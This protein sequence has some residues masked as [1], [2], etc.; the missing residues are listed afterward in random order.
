MDEAPEEVSICGENKFS[1][2]VICMYY[3]QLGCLIIAS[4]S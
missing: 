3:K 1:V 2:C 4:V